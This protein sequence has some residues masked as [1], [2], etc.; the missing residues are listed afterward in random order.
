MGPPASEACRS[1]G[2]GG[3][4]GVGTSPGGQ[5]G[6]EQGVEGLA[7]GRPTLVLNLHQV[8]HVIC[9]AAA[10]GEHGPQR[11]GS[12]PPETPGPRSSRRGS[13]STLAPQRPPPPSA[14]RG[15]HG[16]LLS[17]MFCSRV[18]GSWATAWSRYCRSLL[19][20]DTGMPKDCTNSSSC[21]GSRSCRAEG[22]SCSATAA[23]RPWQD[24]GP[25]SLVGQGWLGWPSP[26]VLRLKASSPS[27][28]SLCFP[29]RCPPTHPRSTPRTGSKHPPRPPPPANS[30]PRGPRPPPAL[31]S[32]RGPAPEPQQQDLAGGVSSE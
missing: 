5:G 21:W 26:C 13:G 9:R 28:C 18:W 1:P 7:S 3:D 12:P 30:R 31:L 29:S 8:S 4:Q 19:M 25:Q 17:M 24:P 15:P 22:G 20:L 32:H 10:G 2:A 11:G 14:R 23:G 6:C 27:E 16:S